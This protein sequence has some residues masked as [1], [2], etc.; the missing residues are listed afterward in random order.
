MI[1]FDVSSLVGA[2]IREDSVPELALQQAIA[3]DL[4][5]VS[6]ALMAELIDVLA[7]PRL[8]RFVVSALREGVLSRV[9]RFGMRFEPIEA[10]TDCRDPKD[11]KILELALASGADVIVSSDRDLLVMHPWRGVRILSP[12]AY[13][14]EAGRVGP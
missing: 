14:A 13:L 10:V 7:R 5:A 8:A 2:A 1:V 6:D 3:G 12:A 4:L 9:R 11:D